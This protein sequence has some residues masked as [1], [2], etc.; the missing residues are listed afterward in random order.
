MTHASFADNDRQ[1]F[2]LS[3]GKSLGR[4]RVFVETFDPLRSV[5]IRENACRRFEVRHVP[6][7]VG[8]LGADV[9][10]DCDACDGGR[11]VASLHAQ[12]CP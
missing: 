9:E 4:A 7:P 3:T 1:W 12:S 8:R 2:L 5:G 11:V 6:Q 10:L